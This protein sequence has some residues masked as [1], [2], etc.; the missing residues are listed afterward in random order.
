MKHWSDM[1]YHHKI[2]YLNC[3]QTLQMWSKINFIRGGR[4]W[5]SIYIM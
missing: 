1:F 4:C 3:H 5:Q 2:H